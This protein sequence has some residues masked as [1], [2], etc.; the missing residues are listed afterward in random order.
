MYLLNENI[1]QR[2]ILFST[3]MSHIKD[4]VCKNNENK[5]DEKN[6]TRAIVFLVIL[7]VKYRI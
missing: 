5:K 1:K 2:F 3:L 4:T 6:F 7:K